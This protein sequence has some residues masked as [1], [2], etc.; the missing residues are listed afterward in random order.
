VHLLIYITAR[1]RRRIDQAV[2]PQ[3]AQSQ[4]APQEQVALL[5]CRPD[6]VPSRPHAHGLQPQCSPQVHVVC[7]AAAPLL[8]DEVHLQSLPPGHGTAHPHLSSQP[9]SP[10]CLA[11]S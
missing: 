5:F 8:A 2:E 4:A 9:I 1:V 3:E 6:G 10:A 7:S 11:G